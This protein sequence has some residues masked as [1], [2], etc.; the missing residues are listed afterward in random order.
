MAKG[1]GTRGP[2][3]ASGKTAN[4]A[5]KSYK[6]TPAKKTGGEKTPGGKAAYNAPI[7]PRTGY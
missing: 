5:A 2:I 7:K 4:T 6:S 3:K 1:C